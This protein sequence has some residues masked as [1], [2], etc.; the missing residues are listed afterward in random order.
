MFNL[1][2]EKKVQPL[3]ASVLIDGKPLSMEMDTGAALSVVSE[4]TWKKLG[5]D[6]ELEFGDVILRTYSKSWGNRRTVD[7]QYKDQSYALPIYI[8]AGSGPA[9]FGCNWMKF[10]HFDW[11]EMHMIVQLQLESACAYIQSN[12]D[13]IINN[14]IHIQH[15]TVYNKQH[16]FNHCILF[17]I[18]C[19]IIVLV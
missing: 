17:S 16:L 12:E 19:S 13:F 11:R 2:K 5:R 10:V 6:R 3:R 7:V 14:I 15:Y 9:L 4:E 1:E 8:V 18:I